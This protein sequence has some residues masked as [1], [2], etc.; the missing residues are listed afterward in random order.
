VG[1][2]LTL[3]KYPE[4]HLSYSEDYPS[5][6]T[7]DER[8]QELAAIFGQ[9]LLRFFGSGA[10]DAESHRHVAPGEEP[11]TVQKALDVS[12]VSDPVVSRLTQERS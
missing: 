8:L 7:C 9:G 2:P 6:L 12:P 11:E 4:V 5:A 3:S 1:Q 10:L